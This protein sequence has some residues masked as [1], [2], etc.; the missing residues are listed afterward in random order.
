MRAL[1]TAQQRYL[2]TPESERVYPVDEAIR[3]LGEY[4]VISIA[5][6]TRTLDAELLGSLPDVLEPFVALSPLLDVI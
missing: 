6:G 1:G 4:V 2:A 5:I 3:K